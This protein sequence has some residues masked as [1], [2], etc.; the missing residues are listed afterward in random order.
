M[1]VS[2]KRSGG[3]AGGINELGSAAGSHQ[4]AL[5]QAVRRLEA[6]A[7]V[8][9]QIGADLFRYELTVNEGGAFETLTV[10]DA[11]PPTSPALRELIDLVRS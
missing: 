1:K 5:G 4:S 6:R 7:G 10:Q 3:F 9:E 8:E 11:D 2:I